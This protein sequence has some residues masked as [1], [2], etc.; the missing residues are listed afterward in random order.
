MENLTEQDLHCMA[1]VLQE[2]LYKQSKFGNSKE[3][4]MPMCMR[5]KYK[6]ECYQLKDGEIVK[7]KH[8]FNKLLEKV[9]NLTG[10]YLGFDIEEV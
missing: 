4:I 6:M 5:C 3:F 2:E 1:R 10:I 7:Y 9:S 8:N